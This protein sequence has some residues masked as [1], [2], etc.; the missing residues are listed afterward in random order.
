MSRI[1][2]AFLACCSWTSYR[3]GLRGGKLYKIFVVAPVLINSGLL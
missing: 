3:T 2:A 1:Y